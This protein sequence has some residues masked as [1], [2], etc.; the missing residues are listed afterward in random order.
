MTKRFQKSAGPAHTP[1]PQ[2][3]SRTHRQ[4]RHAPP[5]SPTSLRSEGS[6][7][8]PSAAENLFIDFFDYSP[9]L[10]AFRRPILNFRSH[11]VPKS[12]SRL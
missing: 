9:P 12:Y 7:T 6:L 4:R 8:A 11:S 5:L 3:L 2:S 1:L 10:A